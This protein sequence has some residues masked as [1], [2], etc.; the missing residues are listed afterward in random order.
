M[1]SQQDYG[2]MSLMAISG[3]LGKPNSCRMQMLTL[4]LDAQAPLSRT[5]FVLLLAKW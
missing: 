1:S 4:R 5:K 2:W 3:D